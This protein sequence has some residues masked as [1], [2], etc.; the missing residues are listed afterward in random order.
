M[1][2]N[3]LKSYLLESNTNLKPLLYEI[4]KQ[5]E[6]K[7]IRYDK[8]LITF[9]MNLVSL[10]PKFEIY[11]ETLSADRQNHDD[12]VEACVEII[13]DDRS[14]GLITLK[15]QH[16]FLQNFFNR[17]EV[18]EKHTKNLHKKTAHLLKEITENDVITKD[19]QDDIFNKVIVDI[20]LNMGLGN[21]ENREVFSETTKALNSVMSRSDKAKFVTLDKKDRLLAL[22]DIREIVCGIRIFNKHAG[23]SANGMSDL[24]RILEQSHESTKSILQITLCE[25]M[26][27]V[28][29]LTSALNSSIAYDLRNRAIVT[30]LPENISA[31]DLDM[32]KDLL[33]MYR[34]HEVY[35]RKM[36]DELALIK[37]NIDTCNQEYKQKLIKLHEAVQ[38]RTA[39]PT[40]RV[41]PKFSELTH[42]W[43]QYQNQ[44][45]LL[46]EINQINNTL[47]NLTERCLSFDD[48][49]YR[50]LGECQVQTDQ[51]RLNKTN[52]KR[53]IVDTEES[54]E[55]IPYTSSMKIEFLKFCVWHLATANGLLMPGNVNM[56]VCQYQKEL[57]AFNIPEPA[58]FFNEDPDMYLFK[59]VK[60]ARKKVQLVAFL[61]IFYKVQ[62]AYN[63]KSMDV[64]RIKGPVTCEQ[65]V[66]TELHPVPSN[67]NHQYRWNIWDLRREAIGLTNLRM[68]QTS[69][70]QTTKTKQTQVYLPKNQTTQ[71]RV[72]RTTETDQRRMRTKKVETTPSPLQIYSLTIEELSTAPRR[73][74]QIK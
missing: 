65:E 37:F 30:L 10:D 26:D 13:S 68:K 38:Y 27:K 32:L 5:C 20:I 71:T 16:Y 52:E 61:D 42:I 24:P 62:N 46:S 72:S 1:I 35:T 39:I 21:P 50:L 63:S 15:M 2:S 11:M 17:D 12:F 67:I 23:N 18:V 4:V 49:A 51:D 48:L 31:D 41:F 57:Y 34:Q 70:S 3:H 36:I 19:E 6:R 53:L 69:S 25:I 56:G 59:I 28:N 66:Q 58:V 64:F 55:I 9:V 14:P 29:L 33:I 40:D 60:L 8:H 47:I 43:L 45:Y 73:I 44:I 22:K 74:F 54:C 7:N